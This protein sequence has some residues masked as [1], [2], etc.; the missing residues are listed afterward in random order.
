MLQFERN[1]ENAAQI[2]VIGIGGGGGNAINRMIETGMQGVGFLSINTDIQ[3]LSLSKAEN[4]LQIGAKLT[5]GLGAGGNPEVGQ[6]AAEENM[7]DLTQF[8][9]GADMVFITCGMGGGTGTGAAPIVAKTAKDMGILTVGVVTKPFTFEGK[10]RR[11][12]AD[13][14]IKFLKKYVDSLVVVPNDKLLAIAEKKTTLDEAFRMADDVLRQ[15]VQGITDLITIPGIINLDF[16]DVKTVMSDRGIAHMGVG[17]GGGESRIKD[18]VRSA[19]ASPL[20]E[21]TIDGAKAILLNVMGGYDLGMMEVSEAA[22]EIAQAADKDAIVI[23]GATVREDMGDGITITVI[24]TGF[25]DKPVPVDAGYAQA[26]AAAGN[27]P[28]ELGAAGPKAIGDGTQPAEFD[29]P[30]FLKSKDI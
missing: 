29:I 5:K 3:A 7:E 11:D 13:L 1:T 17:D 25:E 15:G 26:E 14:G 22:D 24:A 27:A 28:Q 16:A 18:A 8:L 4:R 10:A 21:T 2:K 23:F 12:H 19:I 9:S 20:L 30:A 6:K